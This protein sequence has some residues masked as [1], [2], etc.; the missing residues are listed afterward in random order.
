MDKVMSQTTFFSKYSETH[1]RLLVLLA[2]WTLKSVFKRVFFFFL[3]TNKN[4]FT[5]NGY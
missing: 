5:D 1:D 3:S 4:K 2:L